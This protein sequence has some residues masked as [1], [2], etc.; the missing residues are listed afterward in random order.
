[1]DSVASRYAKALFDLALEE[2]KVVTYQTEIKTIQQTMLEHPELV[3]VISHYNISKEA[4]KE[5]L[6]KIF[7][8]QVSELTLN[9]LG[10]LIDKNRINQVSKVCD[11]FNGFANKHLGVEEGIVYST[12]LLDEEIMTQIKKQIEKANGYKVELKNLIDEK[13]VGG[14]KIVIKD[15]VYDNTLKNKIDSLRYELLEGKR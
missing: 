2:K 14:F 8:K 4:K 13:L 7:E 5:L 12:I 10:L 15:R 9:F 6:N 11:E 3:G 1:M